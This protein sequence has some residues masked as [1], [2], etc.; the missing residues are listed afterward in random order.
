MHSRPMASFGGLCWSLARLMKVNGENG[1]F[2]KP[3][4]ISETRWVASQRFRHLMMGAVD[5]CSSRKLS[6]PHLFFW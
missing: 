1:A 6:N 5:T 3:E 2:L 4:P